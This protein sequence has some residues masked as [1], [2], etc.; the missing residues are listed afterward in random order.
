MKKSN[1]R[2]RYERRRM[3]RDLKAHAFGFVALIV[4]TPLATAAGLALLYVR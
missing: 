1:V 4:G 2:Q 3:V